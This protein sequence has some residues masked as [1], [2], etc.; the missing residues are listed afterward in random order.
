MLLPSPF[1]LTSSLIASTLA[2]S[3]INFT[4][5]TTLT[6]DHLHPPPFG[7]ALYP[8]PTPYKHLSFTGFSALDPRSRSLE[9]L[10]S[11]MDHNCAVSLPNALLGARVGGDGGMKA[12]F[13]IS[14]NGTGAEGVNEKGMGVEGRNP[15]SFDLLGMMVKPLAAPGGKEEIRLGVRGWK[16]NGEK[17]AQ[18]AESVE[19]HVDFPVGYHLMLNATLPM[20]FVGL[21]RVE[22]W[23]DYGPQGLDWEFCVDDLR[24]RYNAGGDDEDGREDDIERNG[25]EL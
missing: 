3:S 25:L 17:K 7:P 22:M 13:E 18:G 1:V 19:W 16:G 21:A 9:N 2:L 23:A 24:V 14:A 11:P 8:P 12:A 15:T 4:N 5:L 10:I 20:E 6:F